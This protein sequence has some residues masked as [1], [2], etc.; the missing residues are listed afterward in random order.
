MAGDSKTTK[1]GNRNLS[2]E[3]LMMGYGYDPRLS[4]SGMD[5]GIARSR[6]GHQRGGDG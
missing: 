3:S 1:I 2:P 6:V 5:D 4:R